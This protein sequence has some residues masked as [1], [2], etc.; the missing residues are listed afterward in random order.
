M[1]FTDNALNQ[2]KKLIAESENP[3][4]GIRFYTAQGCCSPSLQM[5]VAENP[6][7]DDSVIQM[8]GGNIFVTTEAEKMLFDI[9]IDYTEDGFRTK[10]PST[11]NQTG[12]CC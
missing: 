4:A 12:G 1:N 3:K 10:K 8:S 6:A 2:F 5:E 9:T 11:D 7:P